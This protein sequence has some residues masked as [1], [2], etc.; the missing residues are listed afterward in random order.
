MAEPRQ[1]SRPEDPIQVRLLPERHSQP[2]DPVG[3]LGSVQEAE[4]TIEAGLPGRIWQPQYLERLARSYW[5]YLRHVSLGLIRIAYAR[6]ARSVVLVSR[7]L[8][9]LRFRPPVYD[10]GPGFGQVTW[11]IQRGLL[12]AAKG[13]GHLRISARRILAE[14]DQGRLEPGSP[15]E[16]VLVRAEV[17]NFYPLLRG[18]GPFSRL[19][20]RLYAATQLRIHVFVTRGFLRSLARLDL[21]PRDPPPMAEPT[22][23]S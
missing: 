19:G 1:A 10:T 18:R 21:S 7:R 5:Q 8:V 22:R 15:S 6:D 14:T 4:V 13:R 9:L 12:V 17:E 3:P 20:A 23:G 11:P 2:V 16:R